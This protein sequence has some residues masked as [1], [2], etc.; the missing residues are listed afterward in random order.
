VTA[1]V[2]DFEMTRHAL[3]RVQDMLVTPEEIRQAM[4]NPIKIK[5]HY[6]QKHGLGEYYFSG[7]IALVVVTDAETRKRRVITVVWRRD[8]MWAK[9][10][11]QFGPYGDRA[12]R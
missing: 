12:P 10:F 2:E 1:S 5:P 11:R 8:R 7:R 4:L 9:D 6:S 3:E